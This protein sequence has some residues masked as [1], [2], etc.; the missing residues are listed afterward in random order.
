MGRQSK[1]QTDGRSAVS[2]G[3]DGDACAGGALIGRNSVALFS[4]AADVEQV[5]D[6]QHMRGM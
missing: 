6:R 3:G 5:S 2:A 1:S 4:A